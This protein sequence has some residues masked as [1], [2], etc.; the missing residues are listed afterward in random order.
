MIGSII[1]VAVLGATIY[2]ALKRDAIAETLGHAKACYLKSGVL[3]YLVAPFILLLTIATLLGLLEVCPDFMKYG[4][5]SLFS[6]KA[7]G[8]VL[9][10]GLVDASASD[11]LAIRVGVAAVLAVLVLIIPS[12][13]TREER[14]YRRYK[15]RPLHVAVSSLKFGLMHMIMGVSLSAALALSVSGV[16]YAGFYLWQWYIRSKRGEYR[17]E[18]KAFQRVCAL[19]SIYNAYLMAVLAVLLIK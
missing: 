8:N 18:E 12:L 15:R 13:A 4:W 19:H 9:V 7:G 14:D 1:S 5:I 6:G 3:P 16:C 17:A 11:M 2:F 10:S